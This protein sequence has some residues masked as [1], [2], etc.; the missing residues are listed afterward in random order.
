MNYFYVGLAMSLL[1]AV[2]IGFL[3]GSIPRKRREGELLDAAREEAE[4]IKKETLF[5]GRQKIQELREE[6]EE[7]AKE[8]AMQAA[9]RDLPSPRTA[10]VISRVRSTCSREYSWSR[11]LTTE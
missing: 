1:A 9:L 10:L 4:Q 6:Q 5:E 7:R 8:A 2:A 3:L 11:V